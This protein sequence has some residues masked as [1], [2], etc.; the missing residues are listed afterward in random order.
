MAY[1]LLKSNR[2]QMYLMPLSMRD[3]L[4]DNHLA[5]FILDVVKEFDLTPFYRRYRADGWG[6]AA[7]EPG[8]MVALLLY[9]YS[10]GIRS[11]RQIERACE[12]DVAFRVITGNQ[13]PDY[14][15]ICRFRKEFEAELG[16]LFTEVLRLCVEAGL[17]KVGVLALDGTK[18]KGNTSLSANRTYEYLE[19]EVKQMLRE[20]EVKDA[21]ED[22][23]YGEDRRGDELPESLAHRESRLARLKEAKAQLEQ[24]A[25]E[26]ARA[27]K[28]KIEARAVE[29]STMG[30]KRRGRKPKPP[31]EAPDRRAKA[32]LTDLESRI[33]KTSN[34]Y[35]QGY[36]AQ[37]VVTS[38]QVI[39]AA[40]VTQQQNDVGQLHP[41]MNKAS[42]ELEAAGIT[43]KM[44]VML[45][46][47]GYYSE[48]NVL[49]A[50][51]GG[52]ELLLATS[53]DH[54]QRQAMKKAT[55]PQGRIPNKATVKEMMERK[56]LTKR[57]KALYK[58]RSMTV[59][60]V[61]GQIK[62]ARCCNRFMRRGLTSAISEW[63]L[64]SAT[65]NLLKLWRSGKACL[66]S[67]CKK[68][69]WA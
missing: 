33:M 34:G 2:D 68:I 67:G 9:A 22:A 32:N 38:D 35:I 17:V 24:Q 31:N 43:Q 25:Q 65:H 44:R 15:T 1:N 60:P 45:A 63:R 48:E 56:L 26:K 64:I 62:E 53:R 50:N 23:L 29:E 57:G 54:K 14:S 59:E 16:E 51:P 11:S 12:S 7:Y 46:D 49:K 13:K 3:W 6:R 20:A 66:G 37:A 40:E 4:P 18:V 41:M 21:E 27:Q 58:L 5:W 61:F 39:V 36:N 19:K 30:K 69:C 28:E 10:L 42:E 47:A 52:P 55:A 8:M